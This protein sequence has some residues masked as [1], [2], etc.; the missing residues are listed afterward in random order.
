ML[1]GLAKNICRQ[2]F[3]LSPLLKQTREGKWN[4]LRRQTSGQLP[5]S[6]ALTRVLVCIN[7]TKIHSRPGPNSLKSKLYHGIWPFWVEA[8][9]RVLTRAQVNK[10]LS[11][12]VKTTHLIINITYSQLFLLRLEV[13]ANH[14]ANVQSHK[15][16][17]PLMVGIYLGNTK[18]AANETL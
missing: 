2:L 5:Q 11:A 16:I 8:E 14:R 6:S 10:L 4:R 9:I 18:Q 3:F 15:A 13:N 17:P 12:L 1:K 7:P